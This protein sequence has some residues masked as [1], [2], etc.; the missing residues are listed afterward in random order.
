METISIIQ[1]YFLLFM[2]YAIAGWCV[3]EVHCS[4]REKRIVDRGFL[5]GPICPVYGFGGV[6]ITISLTKFIE[7]PTTVFCMAVFLCAILEYF[8][9]YIMEKLFNARWWDYSNDKLNLNGRICIRTLIP[10][11]V[12]GLLIIYLF[13]PLIYKVMHNIGSSEMLIATISLAIIF[14]LDCIV[15]FTVISEVT[16]KAKTI[17]KKNPKDNTDEITEK[18]KVELRETFAGNRLVNAYP[19][20]VTLG[21]KI[22]EFAQETVKKGKE[23]AKKGTKAVKKTA[24]RGKEAVKSTATLGKKAVQNT[25]MRGK[26]AVKKTASKG[27]K[28]LES[29]KD[30]VI[31]KARNGKK[32]SK[33]TTQKANTTNKKETNKTNNTQNQAKN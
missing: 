4:I 1:N 16:S 5:I 26:I 21:S 10:F 20:F 24:T 9:S 15:S 29:E 25:A 12:F 23:T 17:S 31:A 27:K 19:D 33:N 11:G 3:E 6:G 32:Q 14:L 22:K 7:S 13:N 30:R 8:T 28:V 18:V 2:I